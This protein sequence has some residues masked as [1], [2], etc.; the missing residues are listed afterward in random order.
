MK[1][2]LLLLPLLALA[3][4]ALAQDTVTNAPAA[5][6]DIDESVS[7]EELCRRANSHCSDSDS[8]ARS[9]AAFREL[10]KR[11]FKGDD[12]A[13][14]L[15]FW[16]TGDWAL[17]ISFIPFTIRSVEP[18]PGGGT[19]W[20][21]EL[22]GGVR[23]RTADPA[24]TFGAPPDALPGR[25]LG[26]RFRDYKDGWRLDGAPSARSNACVYV[27]GIEVRPLLPASEVEVAREIIAR[28]LDDLTRLTAAGRKELEE[29]IGEYWENEGS[30]LSI[31]VWHFEDGVSF[32]FLDLEPTDAEFEKA[33]CRN[34]TPAVTVDGQVVATWGELAREAI[35]LHRPTELL[36]REY[37]EDFLLR[38][39]GKKY[40]FATVWYFV[41]D[42]IPGEP[43]D[44]AELRT[45]WE[46]LRAKNPGRWG[47]KSFE[48]ARGWVLDARIDARVDERRAKLLAPLLEKAKIEYTPMPNPRDAWRQADFAANLFRGATARK[49]GEENVVL[50]P[51]GVANL[52]AL[53]QTGARGDTARGIS[54]ALRLGGAE[55][56]APDEVAATFREARAS[57]S[58]ASQ[59]DIRRGLVDTL[60]LSDSLWLAPGFEADPDFAA[61]AKDAFAAEVRTTEM[62]A[63]GRKSINAFVSEKT[64]GRVGDLLRPPLLDDPDTR[65]VAVDT[66]YFKARWFNEFSKSS[67]S[68]QV[69]HAPTGD[70]EVPFLHDT[71]TFCLLFDAP[72][73]TAL[74]VA[75]RGGSEMLFLLPS[76][77]NTVADIEEKLGGPWLDRLLST[78]WHGKVSIALPKFEFD[79]EHDLEPILS[80]MGMSAAFDERSADFSGIAP[81]LRLC[82][83][84]QRTSIAVDEEGT[85]AAAAACGIGRP[86][87]VVKNEPRSFIADRPFLFLVRKRRTGLILFLGRVAKP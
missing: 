26:V 67:T 27:G 42:G 80:S 12:E 83:S 13:M 46:E 79:S 61:R 48:E 2:P 28:N 77:S 6:S 69:F 87:G 52:L 60:E 34:E 53:L 43:K 3:L 10:Q 37:A 76:P 74:P 54:S 55:P 59:E 4:P 73:C 86:L 33:I 29:R 1:R 39:E 11:A 16:K 82:A 5:P 20:I 36:T 44:E 30:G 71:R 31:A 70:L 75:Y 40:G 23:V 24:A 66:V 32:R 81:G 18:E 38:R 51:W 85:T 21:V 63:A 64:G 56:P 78:K 49:S 45:L 9:Y 15:Y 25:R 41:H 35:R 65:L 57:L 19:N 47:G 84:V 17:E 50:S 72:E 7:S 68:N 22:L 58:R 62:G 14:S 8:C